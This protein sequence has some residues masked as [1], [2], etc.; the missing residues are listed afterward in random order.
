MCAY[1]GSFSLFSIE[2]KNLR[3]IHRC[4]IAALCLLPGRHARASANRSQPWPVYVSA[5]SNG[6]IKVI[7]GFGQDAQHAWGYS[8]RYLLHWNLAVEVWDRN[9]CEVRRHATGAKGEDTTLVSE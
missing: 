3:N 1:T 8:V 9:W 5:S 6:I 7:Y 2:Q 4:P